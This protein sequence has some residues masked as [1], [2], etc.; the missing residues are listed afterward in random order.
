M[1]LISARHVRSHRLYDVPSVL[2]RLLDKRCPVLKFGL[3]VDTELGCSSLLST[4]DEGRRSVKSSPDIRVSPSV[5]VTGGTEPAAEREVSTPPSSGT[6]SISDA[7]EILSDMGRMIGSAKS[8]EHCYYIYYSTC[9]RSRKAELCRY[10]GDTVSLQR[11]HKHLLSSRPGR[12][13]LV[14]TQHSGTGRTSGPRLETNV[15]SSLDSAEVRR[16]AR[17]F[18]ASQGLRRS[19]SELK[20]DCGYNER[21]VSEC[22]ASASYSVHDIQTRS[23]QARVL[24]RARSNNHPKHPS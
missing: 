12:G 18:Q 5:S 10:N 9:W 8:Y 20:D 15:W 3:L 22:L 4:A 1:S 19:E 7:M 14:N 13:A 16:T 17:G 24:T 23:L 2:I 6:G 21:I 11:N